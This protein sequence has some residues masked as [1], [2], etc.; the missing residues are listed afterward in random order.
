MNF[1]RVLDVPSALWASDKVATHLHTRGGGRNQ[2]VRMAGHTAFLTVD[3]EKSRI[4]FE[5]TWTE[6]VLRY[7]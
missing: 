7:L 3:P 6:E 2:V 1:E 4:Y 5:E